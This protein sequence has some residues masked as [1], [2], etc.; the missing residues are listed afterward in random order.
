LPWP[1]RLHRS[2]RARHP[3]YAFLSLRFRSPER[4]RCNSCALGEGRDGI[5]RTKNY[6]LAGCRLSGRG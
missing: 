4:A 1:R 3:P 2:V 5:R 6:G